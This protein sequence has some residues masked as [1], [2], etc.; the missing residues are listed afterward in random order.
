MAKP[1]T[2]TKSNT[3]WNRELIWSFL[4]GTTTGL[5]S[6]FFVNQLQQSWAP[7]CKSEKITYR[8]S[9]FF[10]LKANCTVNSYILIVFP[11]ASPHWISMLGKMRDSFGGEIRHLQNF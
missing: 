9:T 8:N 11:K 3:Y 10:L 4:E 1:I 5:E 7:I 6:T 2:W